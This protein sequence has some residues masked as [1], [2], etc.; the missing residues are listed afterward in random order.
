MILNDIVYL[1]LVWLASGTA[2]FG[3]DPAFMYV[4]VCDIIQA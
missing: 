4:A 3:A 2:L 1:L